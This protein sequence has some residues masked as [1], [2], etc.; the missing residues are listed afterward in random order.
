M[1]NKSL[2]VYEYISLLQEMVSI[3]SFS[4]KEDEVC[5]RICGFLDKCNMAYYRDGN[6]II[7]LNRYFDPAQKSLMLNAHID[8]V[9][10]VEGY[11]FDPYNPDYK[12]AAS[13][14]PADPSKVETGQDMHSENTGYDFVCGLG[15][16]DDGA[17]V[18]S[19][20]AAFRHF[21][22]E[23]MPINLILV[24]SAEEERSGK[25]GMDRVWLKFP[26][27]ISEA[28]H[29]ITPAESIE[30]YIHDGKTG[31]YTYPQWAI[32]GEPTGM[33]AAISERGLLVIDAVAEGISGHA[34]RN[35]GVNS[36]YIAIEDI[37]KLR[38]HVFS[39]V[40]KS[41]GN[42]NMNVTQINAGTAHNIIPDRCGFVIDI[43]PTE[44]YSNKEILDELQAICKSRLNA[45]NLHNKSSATPEKSL[46]LDCVKSMGINTFSS[47]T[48]SD[49]MR[50]NCE[51]I[52]MGP[53]ES[54][55]SH[56]KDEFVYVSEIEKA[57]GIYIDFIKRF[58]CNY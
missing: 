3:P 39:K 9:P 11:T 6:N 23:R 4:F 55:R 24:L 16:N 31:T 53:G 36:I 1:E 5:S 46:L 21:Y 51:A 49:W 45:R 40:S 48:T 29:N 38:S 54:S 56:K 50:I 44:K 8:T 43:R 25:D 32:I 42:V 14:I 57:I 12:A 13:V 7:V 22:N 37:E 19:M 15:S 33:S 28:Y 26:K 30:L 34:A 35:E 18:V 17:S 10:P 20:L 41:M 58:C 2:Y 47:P 52:K 27:I